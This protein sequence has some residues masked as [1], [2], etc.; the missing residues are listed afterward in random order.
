M[1]S[2]DLNMQKSSSFND[3]QEEIDYEIGP[4]MLPSISK[5]KEMDT[6]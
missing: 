3:Y 2:S 5:G 6:F 1:S 4:D